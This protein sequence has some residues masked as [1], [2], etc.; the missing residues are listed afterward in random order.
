MAGLAAGGL[1]L[2]GCGVAKRV[3]PGLPGGEP[4]Q[5][6]YQDWRTE[7]FPPMVREM[8]E[9]FHAG[10]PNIRVFYTPDP[11]DLLERM[12]ADM[13][14]GIAA[15]VFQGC[16]GHFPTWAQK[17]WTVDLRR[18]MDANFQKEDLADWDPVQYAALQAADGLQFGVPKYHGALALYFNRD[19]FDRSQVGYP[20]ASWTYAEYEEAM[21]AVTQRKQGQNGEVTVWGGMLDV[22]WDRLQVHANAW[23]GHF[24]N[25][26]DPTHC[27][28]GESESLA[29]ME[30]IRARMWDDRVMAASGDVQKL[31]TR[32]AFI[33]QRV[34][35]VED[36]SWALKDILEKAQFRV[37][38]APMPAGPA[39]RVTLA[40][41][42]GFGI[43]AGTRYPEAAWELVK[44]LISK[45]YG[46]AMAKASLLQPSR[47]SLVEEWIGIVQQQF[48]RA[49]D[50]DVG[51]FA[52]GQR[53]GYSVTAE[54]FPN[55]ADATR[56]ADEAWLKI[57][58]QGL[59]PVST[60]RTV[61]AEIGAAQKDQAAG[62][63][64]EAGVVRPG[65]K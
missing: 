12:P 42:D 35:M 14:A 33:A 36:G 40:T 63:S 26:T 59:A 28:M 17:G 53:Q 57:F 44:F 62:T 48:P 13:R 24:V 11:E 6:V 60:L 9:L 2:A 32:D 5:L 38:V 39:R 4:V 7:W 46:R 27:L 65:M 34:A 30:W 49:R 21:K 37:G 23:G 3:I 43:Y 8:L 10:H 15:D 64:R 47:L 16:C 29:A 1:F 22:S 20:K 52:E 41:S 25:P 18:F 50:M 45:E 58:T 61:A 55:M 54:I 51:V 56:L 31:S 19:L